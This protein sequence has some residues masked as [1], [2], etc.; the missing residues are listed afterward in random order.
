MGEKEKKLTV[1]SVIAFV[2]VIVH[3]SHGKEPVYFADANLKAAVEQALGISDPNAKEMLRLVYLSAKG[4]DIDDLTGLEYATNIVYLDLRSNNITSIQPLSGLTKIQKLMLGSN[5]QITN[6][7]PLSGMTNLYYLDIDYHYITNIEPLSGLTN[8]VYLGLNT[9]RVGSTNGIT[10][11]EPLSGLTKLQELYLQDNRI[12]NIQPL[13][14]LTKLQVLSLDRN[15]ITDIEP[16]SGLT[17]LCELMLYSNHQITNIQPLSGLTNLERLGLAYNQI[18]DIE[19]LSGLTNLVYL[20]LSNNLL[21]REAYDVYIPLIKAN[22]PG[23]TIFYDLCPPV[24]SFTYSPEKPM[25]GGNIIFDASASKA[26]DPDGTIVSYEWNFGDGYTASGQVVTYMYSEPGEYTV[27]LTVTD[28]DGLTDSNSQTVQIT[29]P[30]IS[31]LD[32]ADLSRQ[33][34]GAA[35]DGASKV[36][37]QITGLPEDIT[38]DDIQISIP[39]GEADGRLEN[40]KKISN[41][42]FTQTYVVPSCFVRN[43]H[44]EDL[45]AQ[46]REIDLSI[47]VKGEQIDHEPFTLI[48]PPVVMVHGL[49]GNPGDFSKLGD[50]LTEKGWLYL[51]CSSYDNK[52]SFATNIPKV[53]ADIINSLNGP[54]RAM[55]AATKVDVVAHSM[56]G[57]LTKLIDNAFLQKNVRKII[58]IGTPHQGSPVADRV[59]GLR[60][61]D[62]VKFNIIQGIFNI[63]ATGHRNS[64]SGGAVEDLRT[65]DANN[66]YMNIPAEVPGVDCK[67]IILGLRDGSPGQHLSLYLTLGRWVT[68][69][70]PLLP[71]QTVHDRIFGP[72]VPS[73][74]VVSLDSQKGDST[75]FRPIPVSWHIIEPRDSDFIQLVIEFLNQEAQPALLLSSLP[76]QETNRVAHQEQISLISTES[77]S[78]YIT[79]S[80]AS[81]PNGSVK[82]VS[83]TEGETCTAGQSITISIQGTGDT[84]QAAL[85]ALFG[86]SSWADIVAIPWVGDVNVPPDSVGLSAK[87]MV[88]GLTE[89]MN[90]TDEDEVNLVLE[91]DIVLQDI[92]L[93]FGETWYF[94]FVTDPIQSRQLQLYPMG[95]FSDGSE[96]PLSVLG[97]QTT[98]QSLNECVATVD[99]NGI[100]TVHS[101]GQDSIVVTN[102]SITTTV[103]IE[104]DTYSGD[105][106]LDGD[107]DFVDFALF[108]N[109]WQEEGCI[110]LDGNGGVTINDLAIFTEHWL[111][112]TWHPIP[113]D[114]NGDSKIN[115]ADFSLFA[116][117]WLKADCEESNNWCEGTDFDHIGSVDML[118]LAT[119]ASHWLE[120]I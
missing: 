62:P 40:D 50:T 18:I 80:G 93:G 88:I 110:D 60:E 114:L 64:L 94:D 25:V 16:L 63:L 45:T 3:I 27:A 35:A 99:S 43:G 109:Q 28:N 52:A 6:I 75:T 15:Q 42:V 111:E 53:K 11:I 41:A 29:A 20:D 8:L 95:R 85:F 70:N 106:D 116:D 22:N 4:R 105:L 12:T 87:I 57:C 58:T 101:K 30:V 36:V 92:F 96:H 21:N 34:I 13:S 103:L 72:G 86:T 33:V 54:R 67:N 91:S 118:D 78:H 119:F 19:P 32:K 55:Y 108:A 37:I 68:G 97:N 115:F 38:S 26:Y 10:N 112:G 89:D 104:V 47:I 2:V 98:Y 39:E 23:I 9:G 102:S 100:I 90:M 77:T 107:V 24:A 65:K 120:G 56:G 76:T 83:P 44:L 7:E 61:T 17:N 59:F 79:M 117:D 49:W 73:D 82:I 66:P 84:S 69:T 113:G 48:R 1:L 71:D 46:E 51:Y 14:N 74:W 5:H 81:E 31:F